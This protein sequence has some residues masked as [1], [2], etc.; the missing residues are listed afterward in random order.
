MRKI[1][2]QL[3]ILALG[4]MS[5]NSNK[6]FEITGQLPD[7]SFDGEWIYLVP[8]V[9]APVERVDSTT[10]RDGKFSFSG[11]VDLPE[12]Y[13]IRAKPLLRISLQELLVVKEP[14]KL[15]VYIGKNSSVAGTALNDSLQQWKEQKQILDNQ[16]FLLYK[17]QKQAGEKEKELVEDKIS[18]L[19]TKRANY[20]FQFAKNNKDNVV[21]EL[22]IRFM[23]GAFTPEQR[24][25][26]GVD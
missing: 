22:V 1:V 9:N 25:E 26:L 18:Q 10:I 12:I 3:L 5:C 7:K 16:L 2:L 6:E 21:G 20:N 24:K 13:V 14:G 23:K 19:R 8:M 4:F 15:Q 17:S 11:K